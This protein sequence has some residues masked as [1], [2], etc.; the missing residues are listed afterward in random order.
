MGPKIVSRGDYL[1]CVPR[2]TP[3]LLSSTFVFFL[4]RFHTRLK[5]ERGRCSLLPPPFRRS[6]SF[7][8][9]EKKLSAGGRAIYGAGSG[10]GGKEEAPP[11]IKT[12]LESVKDLQGSIVT[13]FSSQDRTKDTARNYRCSLLTMRIRKKGLFLPYS[14][15]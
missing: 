3:L 13:L 1:P 12:P 9:L 14:S 4:I 6:L 7:S 2:Y 11:G 8:R 5:R 10:G 15:T